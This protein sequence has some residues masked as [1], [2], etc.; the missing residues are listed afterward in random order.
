MSDTLRGTIKFDPDMRYT[1]AGKAVTN[2]D[3]TDDDG[4]DMPCVAWEELAEA[5]YHELKTDDRVFVKGYV[6]Y[7]NY[8]SQDELIINRIW[9]DNEGELAEIKPNQASTQEQQISKNIISDIEYAANEILRLSKQQNDMIFDN[10]A[11]DQ[12]TSIDQDYSAA[13]NEHAFKIIEIC[14]KA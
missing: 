5:I 9:I 13:I 7:S 1:G 10:Y 6:K 8:N 3:I 4:K 14:Q 2:L 11:A 12:V